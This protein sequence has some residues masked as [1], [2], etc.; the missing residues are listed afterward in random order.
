MPRLPALL[1]L[2]AAVP[3]W[4]QQLPEFWPG[5]N[6]DPRIPTFRQVLGY[7]AGQR[8]TS[9]AGI[10]RYLDALA[11]ASPRVRIFEYGETWEGRKL[12]YAAIGSE[13]NIR[14]LDYLR[15]AIQRF[16]DPRKTSEAEARKSAAALP[17]VVWL[18]Y[19]VH[20]DEISPSEAALMTAYHLLAARNDK[21]VE[22]IL[23]NDIV[24][25]DPIQNPDGRERFVNYY[26][27]TRGAEPDVHPLAA[28][29]NQP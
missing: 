16:A 25:I 18:S 27:E 14:K 22:S 4:P 21:M 6:Y 26:R 28:E 2:A 15:S 11:A 20:G 3:L 23:A 29:H 9:H 8:I 12:V 19:G 5:A 13:A 10:L 17:A 1:L 7:D 24:L